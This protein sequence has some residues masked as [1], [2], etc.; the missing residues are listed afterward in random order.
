MY[1]ELFVVL[2]GIILILQLGLV[3]KR[4]KLHKNKFWQRPVQDYITSTIWCYTIKDVHSYAEQV[5]RKVY[6]N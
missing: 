1:G 4:F 3:L 6:E 2:V 5:N